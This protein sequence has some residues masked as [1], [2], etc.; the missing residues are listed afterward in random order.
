M[1]DALK[2]CKRQLSLFLRKKS[3]QTVKNSTRFFWGKLLDDRLHFY[4]SPLSRGKEK[5]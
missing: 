5:G 3:S 2:S 4:L 1:A